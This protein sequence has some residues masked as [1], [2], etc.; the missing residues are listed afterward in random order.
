MISIIV[1][2][3]NEAEFIGFTLQSCL[4]F[5]GTPEI[6]VVDNN[7][8]DDS[9]DVV[10]NFNNRTNII[11]KNI[12]RYMPGEAI[13]K[14]VKFATNDYILVL[15]GHAQIINLNFESIKLSLDKHKA[16]FGQ[17][18]PIHR[19][20]K[21]TPGYIWTNFGDKEEINKFSN[22][23]NRLFLHNAFCFYKKE[24]LIKYPM[25]EKYAGKED[26]FWAKDMVDNNHS[27][28]YDPQHKCFHFWTKNG[29]TWKGLI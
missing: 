2:N 17:Q 14:G 1:R 3:K 4:D 16:V 15:S 19:G 6:I 13:N 26:R 5:F 20:K 23:E 18:I 11:I 29:A 24:T 10:Q 22:I 27:Y 25:P 21:I 7:S 28:L 12:N 9:L 8:T